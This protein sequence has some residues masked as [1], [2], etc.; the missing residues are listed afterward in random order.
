VDRP[1]KRYADRDIEFDQR[2][3]STAK[4]SLAQVR[5]EPGFPSFVALGFS[6]ARFVFN[7]DPRLRGQ[8]YIAH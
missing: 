5:H 2:N 4:V 7:G 6:P 3:A 8:R 1:G